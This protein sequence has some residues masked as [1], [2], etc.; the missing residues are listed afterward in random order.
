[1]ITK[2]IDEDKIQLLHK[3]IEES[4]EIVIITHMS[5]D[6]D[7]VGSSLG[8]ANFLKLLKKKVTVIVPNG[9]PDFLKWMHGSSQIINY[10][11]QSAFAEGIIAGTDLIFALDFNTLSRIGELAAAAGDSPAYKILIDHHPHPG[12]FADL[13]ISY[14]QIA[15]TSEMIFRVICRMGFFTNITKECAECIYTGMMTDTGAFTYNS[16][17]PEIYS[18]VSELIKKGINKDRIY[19]KVYNNFSADRFRLM[20]YAL[21]EK[22]KIYPE[23]GTALIFLTRDE[24]NNF[25]YKKGDT[26]GFVNL[27]L[28]IEN[29]IFSVFM[30]E[31]TD[32]IKI[33]F[34]SRGAFPVNQFSSNHFGGGGHLNAAGGESYAS[35]A[36][37]IEKFE[38]LLP[39]Y[40][41]ILVTEMDMQKED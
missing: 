40:N 9:F 27:P 20:G 5:P 11:E 6:G 23:Y 8:F 32:K 18:I 2:I 28:S 25:H 7:A 10:Q 12:S 22:M 24:L 17:S 14:P 35:M 1:M 34:R 33:S 4:S 15:S 39:L 21:N 13:I 37:T 26:E 16:N 19:N 29:I 30:K 41:D 31:D 36:E 3:K 38:S